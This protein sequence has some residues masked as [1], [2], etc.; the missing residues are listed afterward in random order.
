MG[1]GRA[2]AEWQRLSVLLAT[3][4]NCH[5]DPKRGRPARPDDFYRP[6]RG[7]R[8]PSAEADDLTPL[9]ETFCGRGTKQK[10]K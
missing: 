1:Q 4:V 7:R 10:G 8:R 5:R 3:V 6:P 2:D 9:R